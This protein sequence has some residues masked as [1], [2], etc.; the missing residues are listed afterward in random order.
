VVDQR[1]LQNMKMLIPIAKQKG[2]IYSSLSFL[3]HY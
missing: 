1:N 2:I 3:F